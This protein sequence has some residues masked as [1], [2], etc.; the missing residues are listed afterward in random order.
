MRAGRHGCLSENIAWLMLA[1][2]SDLGVL[3]NPDKIDFAVPFVVTNAEH[4]V[5]RDVKSLCGPIEDSISQKH[6]VFYYFN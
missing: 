6:V 3:I 5:A 4:A 2:A 1:D